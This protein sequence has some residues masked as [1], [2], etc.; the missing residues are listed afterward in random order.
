[1]ARIK[2]KNSITSRSQAE[3]SMSKLNEIDQQLARW[4]LAEAD[5]IAAVRTGH[6]ETQRK[7]GRPG[8]EA[9]KALLV[10]EIEAWAETDKDR[11]EKKS[12]ET[13]FGCFGFRVS[14]PTVALIKKVASKFDYA[15]TYLKDR[16]PQYVRETPQIDK[17]QILADAR[18]EVLD[19][20][21]LA[22]CGLKVDQDDEF[23]VET[24]AS[25]DLEAAAKKLRAA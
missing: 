21:E 5:A 6:A 3:A 25:K 12:I 7:G 20:S 22:K 4:D 10:K 23:W 1:M 24:N 17:E 18:A 15:L 2:P 9:E 19:E 14:Q 11:W 16:L 8:L 13:P